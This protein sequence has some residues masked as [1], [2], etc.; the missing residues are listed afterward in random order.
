MCD[1]T[2]VSALTFDSFVA[3]LWLNTNDLVPELATPKLVKEW[4][5]P[6]AS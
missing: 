4:G 2:K 6:R 3:A 5:P 1:G